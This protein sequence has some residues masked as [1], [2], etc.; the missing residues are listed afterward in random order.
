M[1]H[2]HLHA[3]LIFYGWTLVV[4]VGVLGYMFMPFIL[5]T[6]LIVAGLIV[7]TIVT[8]LP[9]T[10]AKTL[11]A[12][13]ESTDVGQ[14]VPELARFDRLDAASVGAPKSTETA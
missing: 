7:C 10:R 12:A 13:A 9:L 6:T 8:V 14:E 3:V 11:E 1:G 4:S 5:A 2:T